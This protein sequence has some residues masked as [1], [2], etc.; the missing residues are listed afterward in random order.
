MISFDAVSQI[1]R[2]PAGPVQACFDMGF[3]TQ[4]AAS[5]TGIGG[6]SAR[7]RAS[8]EFAAA[9]YDA[10]DQVAAQEWPRPSLA[11]VA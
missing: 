7:R 1:Y 10:V 11:R 3:L 4:V 8:P 6:Y 5:K 9:I 2:R